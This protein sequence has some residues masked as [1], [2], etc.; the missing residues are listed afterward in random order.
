MVEPGEFIKTIATIGE[1]QNTPTIGVFNMVAHTRH[2]MA[3]RKWQHLKSTELIAFEWLDSHG[4]ARYP[5]VVCS[6][7]IG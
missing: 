5:N 7:Y 1:E 4:A 3:G 6:P 2:I